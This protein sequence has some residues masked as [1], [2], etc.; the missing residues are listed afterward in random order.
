MKIFEKDI[1]RSIIDYLR[2]KGVLCWKNSTGGIYKKSTDSYIP[3]QSVGA[4]DIFALDEG[5]FYGIE[6]KRPGGK[7]SDK[8]SEF[9]RKI[10]ENGGV[11]IVATSIDDVAKHL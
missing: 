2:L 6:V 5:T 7:L 8:Q 1:Q 9:L 4:P 10:E 11:A 3:S